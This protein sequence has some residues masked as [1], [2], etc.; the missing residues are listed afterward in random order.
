MQKLLVTGSS[1]LIGSEV[2][3]YFGS[4][5]WEVYG[6]DNNQRAI[7]FGLDGDTSWNLKR[8]QK[9]LGDSYH[10]SSL[11]I[12]HRSEILEFVR[13]VRPD[14]VVH[15]PA[16]PSHDKAAAISF[17]DFDVNAVGTLNL[18]EAVRQVCPESP[19]VHMSTSKVYGDLPNSIRLKELD[20]R[21]DCDDNYLNGISEQFSIGQSKHSLL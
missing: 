9:E 14:A 13:S 20:S 1:G 3:S 12:R 8:L 17:D 10:H 15:A 6:I 11:D 16:Q 4:R 21:W 5:G 7:F 2:C 19:F 18:L